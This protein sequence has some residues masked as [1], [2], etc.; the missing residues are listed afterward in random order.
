MRRSEAREFMREDRNEE[1]R[2]M[3]MREV[4]LADSLVEVSLQR[5]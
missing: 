3:R 1:G 2:K 4:R 5:T